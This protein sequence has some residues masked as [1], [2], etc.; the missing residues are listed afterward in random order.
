MC[1]APAPRRS[2]YPSP[3]TSTS[4]GQGAGSRMRGKW[5]VHY[6]QSP[7][8]PRRLPLAHPTR[9]KDSASL[10]TITVCAWRHVSHER[11]EQVIAP[12][13]QKIMR[14]CQSRRDRAESVLEIKPTIILRATSNNAAN[15]GNAAR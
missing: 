9:P 8:N 10:L 14:N 11:P 1:L 7:S 12:R 6:A 2:P 5:R 13:C 15:I 4:E 3:N